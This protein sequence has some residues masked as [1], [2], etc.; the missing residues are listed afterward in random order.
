MERIFRDIT[1]ILPFHTINAFLLDAISSCLESKSCNLYLLLI[2][3]RATKASSNYPLVVANSNV[4]ILKSPNSNY[5]SALKFG[6]ANSHTEFIGLMNSDDLISDQRFTL[7]LK[8]LEESK[9]DLCLAKMIK[10][11]N[12]KFERVPSLLGDLNCSIYT[13]IF[14][15]LG[16][17]GANA[18]WVFKKDWAI[19]NKLFAHRTDL[20]DWHIALRLFWK[21]KISIVNSELYYYRMHSYQ[22]TKTT[23]NIDN[24]VLL[25]MLSKFNESLNLPKLNS[26]ELEVIAGIA[27]PKFI[28]LQLDAE[29]ILNWFN[30]F[31]ELIISKISE[32]NGY[33]SILRRRKLLFLLCS[34]NI[35]F[36]DIKILS[37]TLLEL[38]KL[39]GTMRW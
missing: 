32:E 19:K 1:V 29:K 22:R 28:S 23:K 11:R 26:A 13:P 25:R 8:E 36:F 10:F 17:Y 24:K 34:R 3:T 37:V 31:E 6:L 21:S 4:T 9:S 5:I 30:S 18:T 35:K 14:L 27:R 12:S 15:L 33:N 16:S 39:R 2:D 38:I 20:S 7:Q